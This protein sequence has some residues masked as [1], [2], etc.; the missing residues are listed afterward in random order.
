M[1]RCVD[2][3][4]SMAGI[5][6]RSLEAMIKVDSR[7]RNPCFFPLLLTPVEDTMRVVRHG[8]NLLQK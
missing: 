7:S 2:F 1:R 5:L 6:D 4:L 8:P 3:G